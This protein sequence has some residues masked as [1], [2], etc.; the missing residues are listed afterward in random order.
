ME[1]GQKLKLGIAYILIFLIALGLD[2]TGGVLK[3]DN[4]IERE[5]IGG[6]TIDVDLVLNVEELIEDYE[7][8]LEVEPEKITKE[9]ADA[10][11]L[12]AI[13][14]IEL[15]FES[16]EIEREVPIQTSYDN[17]LVEAEWSFSPSGFLDSDGK[18]K[19]EKVPE[20][21]VVITAKVVLA[22][23]IYETIYS[24]P[25]EI[26]K[27]KLTQWEIVEKSLE[28]WFSYQQ[29][30]E[31]ESLFQLPEELEGFSLQ[32][33]EKKDFFAIKILCL[34]GI[35]L[36]LLIVGRKKEVENLERKRKQKRDLQ[37]PEISNQLLVLLETGM[38]TRQA[39]HKMAS[40]Y[41]EKR[42]K[43][44]VEES[45]VY[46]AIVRMDRLLLEGE[47]EKAAY[48]GFVKQMDT[49][50]YR[51]L[52]RLLVN[53]LEKGSKDICQQL[54]IEAKQAYEQRL[55]TAKKIGEEASTKMLIPMMLMMVLVMLIVTAPAIMGFS[56]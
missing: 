12:E 44:L 22:C 37:Y 17:G 47:K 14:E 5:E 46:E 49:M 24:F 6:D 40:Q 51:R 26:A 54:N 13:E 41:K 2:M 11:F 7:I 4:T 32:W 43:L 34:E 1:K 21:G 42:K 38:T 30:K 56:I 16:T 15:T 29:G 27:P 19:E 23:G 25:F 39:W 10:Y 8:H 28:E 55:L 33:K 50:C 48:E 52:I 35:S 9:K 36:I 18:M 45:E 31:G 53:N 20:E 3:K